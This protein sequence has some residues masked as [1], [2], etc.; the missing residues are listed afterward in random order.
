MM[1]NVG[2]YVVYGASGVCEIVG[3]EVKSLS[4]ASQ[5]EYCKL[6]PLQ[7]S[8]S[9]YYV[10]LDAMPQKVR[11]LMSPD[12]I[13]SLICEVPGIEPLEIGDVR[14]KRLEFSA[15]MKS[16][17]CRLLISLIKRLYYEQV[18]RASSGK[19]PNLSDDKLM[20]DALELVCQ[21][22]SLSLGVG[23]QELAERIMKLL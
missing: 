13:D 2:Q 14:K 16:T 18:E 5:V 15:V 7:T 4:N 20:K 23:K 12:E 21:E 1:F 9:V 17:D 11:E 3:F 6:V 19:K 10:P 22:F 8:G